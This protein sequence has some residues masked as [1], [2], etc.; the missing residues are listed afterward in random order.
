MRDTIIKHKSK[1]AYLIVG[2]WNTLFGYG[3]FAFMYFLLSSRVH[4]T[5]ILT[6][7][8][9]LSIT[10][11]FIGYKLFVFKTKGNILR[12]YIRFY[13]VYGGAFLVNLALLPL[14]MNVMMLSAYL[15]QALITMLTVVGSYIFHN[16]F[17]FR[18]QNNED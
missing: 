4:S 2:G 6:I 11:A 13:V 10:N 16:R 15:S 18:F 3:A 14:F 12:E 9:V 5:L 8:Y 17:T 1:I 7:S